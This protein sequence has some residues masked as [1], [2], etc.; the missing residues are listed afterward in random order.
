MNTF[1]KMNK[2]QNVCNEVKFAYV[3][4]LCFMTYLQAR[5]FACFLLQQYCAIY[6]VKNIKV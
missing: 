2:M 6:S 3:S 1:D 4:G 5:I